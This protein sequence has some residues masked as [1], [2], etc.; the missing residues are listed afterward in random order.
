MDTLDSLEI[1]KQKMSEYEKNYPELVKIQNR[2]SEKEI[3]EEIGMWNMPTNRQHAFLRLYN[4]DFIVEEKTQ[5]NTIVY[6]NDL[7]DNY[8]LDTPNIP[9]TQLYAQMIKY[10]CST[11]SAIERVSKALNIRKNIGYAGLKDERALTA[12]LISFPSEIPTLEQI[13]TT[14]IPQVK[15]TKLQ[16]HTDFLR[17]GFLEGNY[18][19]ITL[20]TQ[21]PINE[22]ELKVKL[23]DIRQN[24]VLNYYQKQ[25]FGG[26]RLEN[27]RTGKL[28]AQGKIEE[29]VLNIL[30]KDSPYELPLVSEIRKLGK[31]EWPNYQTI[32]ELYQELPQTFLYEIKLLSH[33]LAYPNDYIGALKSIKDSVT[34]CIY[35]YTSLLF[36]KYISEYEKENGILKGDIPLLLSPDRQDQAIY[37]KYLEEDQTQ[38]FYSNLQKLRL[39]YFAK[40]TSPARV[41]IKDITYRIFD[42][43]VVLSF[44][45]GKGSYATTFLANLFELLESD[46]VPDWV[47]NTRFDPLELMGRK[48]LSEIKNIFADYWEK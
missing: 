30:F 21:T 15:I 6:V 45:L 41:E 24:G 4:E 17:P 35:G 7:D 13:L 20:R 31:E 27:H 16:Y 5:K 39:V 43:G 23:D 2:Q 37:V 38:D 32:L 14:P 48:G 22:D 46:P 47:K 12:Q 18:F 8:T 42:G 44:F 26:L 36:N 1:Q 3:F 9:N 40:R 33:L 34:L 11:H 25:R 19:T 10:G 28:L 29:A